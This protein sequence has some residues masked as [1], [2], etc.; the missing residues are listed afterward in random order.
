M[1]TP[2]LLTALLFTSLVNLVMPAA[3]TTPKG[4]RIIGT[5]QTVDAKAEVVKMQ[6]EEK[7]ALLE[8]TWSNRTIFIANGKITDAAILKKGAR[9]EVICHFP[10]FG[11]PDVT[12]VTL[13]PAANSNTKTK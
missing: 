3:A 10:F 2:T 11:K 1:R 12:K 7:S 13:L 4:T 6:R 9:V 8:F 5:I